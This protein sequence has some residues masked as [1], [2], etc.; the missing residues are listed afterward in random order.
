MKFYLY[1]NKGSKLF[2][3]KLIYCTKGK[4]IYG[5][6]TKQRKDKHPDVWEKLSGATINIYRDDWKEIDLK[7]VVKLLEYEKLYATKPKRNVTTGKRITRVT[8]SASK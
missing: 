5:I 4:S 1:S 3:N 6:Y 2:Y 7:T 8:K